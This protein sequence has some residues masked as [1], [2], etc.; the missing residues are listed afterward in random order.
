MK[1][2]LFFVLFIIL[3]YVYIHNPILLALGERGAIKL[4]YP[5]LL[6]F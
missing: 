3:L 2:I 6:F 5:I 4:I 1:R